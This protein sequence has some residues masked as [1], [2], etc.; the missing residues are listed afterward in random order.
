VGFHWCVGTHLRV[1]KLRFWE[2]MCHTKDDT[3]VG[4][5]EGI[6]RWFLSLG[7]E[8]GFVFL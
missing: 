1:E 6:S 2:K 3:M 7:K 5:S 8:L 4:I